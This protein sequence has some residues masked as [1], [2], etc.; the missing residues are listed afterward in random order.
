MK[1]IYSLNRN[2]SIIGIT[3]T[4][5]SGCNEVARILTTKKE[6][7]FKKKIVT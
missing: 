1:H 4:M 7:F 6:T 5:G 3:G 2:F